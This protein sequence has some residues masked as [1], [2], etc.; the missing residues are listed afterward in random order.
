[1]LHNA[2]T[3]RVGNS[4]EWRVWVN[5]RSRA[6][7]A[8]CMQMVKTRMMSSYL[9]SSPLANRHLDDEWAN[10]RTR[11]SACIFNSFISIVQELQ[12]ICFTDRWR[13]QHTHT[14]I[15]VCTLD[16]FNAY[17]I[18]WCCCFRFRFIARLAH[19]FLNT[20]ACT[21][22]VKQNAFKWISHYIHNIHVT[23][24]STI[25]LQY[26]RGRAYVREHTRYPNYRFYAECVFQQVVHYGR[27]TTIFHWFF[28]LFFVRSSRRQW[29]ELKLLR[30]SNVIFANAKLN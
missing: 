28:L 16:W 1:M 12:R 27:N 19:I 6:R 25:Y 23:M 8:Y 4:K 2:H 21:Q 10:I 9:S 22:R 20:Y 14:H 30:K 18:G 3:I 24:P 7:R 11:S 13:A 15:Y 29:K 5:A 26:T 17:R